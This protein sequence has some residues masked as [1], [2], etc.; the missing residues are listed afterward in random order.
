M[1][2][3]SDRQRKAFFAQRGNLRTE[4]PMI[5]KDNSRSKAEKRG[6]IVNPKK[7]FDKDGKRRIE[8]NNILKKRP[9][10]LKELNEFEKI[11]NKQDTD[12]DGVPD[13]KDCQ[14]F[15][16]NKQGKLHDL[17]IKA[18]RKKEEF[19]ERRREKQMSKLE[20]LKD[21]LA[22]RNALLSERRGIQAQKQEI[23]N[24]T[25][26]ERKKFKDLKIANREAKAELRRTSGFGRFVAGT[27]KAG[28]KSREILKKTQKALRKFN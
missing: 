1:P 24:E 6:V 21:K 8:L 18:L 22:A 17:A 10:T 5:I 27:V 28:K 25:L 19:V 4:R 26:R 2:F 7:D 11:Y 12:K 14:P 3:K 9:L 15:N 16:P 13:S 23:R 20:D